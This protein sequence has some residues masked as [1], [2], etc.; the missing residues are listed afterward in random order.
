LKSKESIQFGSI[1]SAIA[2][3]SNDWQVTI[4]DPVIAITSADQLEARAA[5][6]CSALCSDGGGGNNTSEPLK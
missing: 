2:V 5:L 1:R 6:V 3:S 4:L